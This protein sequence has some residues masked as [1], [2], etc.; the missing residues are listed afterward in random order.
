MGIRPPSLLRK[1]QL[2]IVLFEI[3]DRVDSCSRPCNHIAIVVAKDGTM[4]PG[5]DP[6][7]L[8]KGTLIGKTEELGA[9][10]IARGMH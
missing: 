4:L 1:P 7:I 6:V 3:K 9:K 5:E 2:G 10:R 8:L